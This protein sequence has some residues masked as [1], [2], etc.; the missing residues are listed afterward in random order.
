MAAAYSGPGD[1]VEAAGSV[2]AAAAPAEGGCATSGCCTPT[3]ANESMTTA[4]SAVGSTPR[5][6]A[7]LVIHLS[8]IL[9]KGG[10]L[11]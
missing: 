7:T 10:P 9:L 4:Q 6:L 8:N 2:G 3:F 11:R 1:S 5:R